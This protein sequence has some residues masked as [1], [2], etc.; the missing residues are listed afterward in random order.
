MRTVA[1]VVA[2]GLLLLGGCS[3]EA[4]SA[5]PSAGPTA[6]PT[7]GPDPSA[8]ASPTAPDSAPTDAPTP[9]DFVA[10]GIDCGLLD[11]T[12]QA[13]RDDAA[14]SDGAF[15]DAD[16]CMANALRS[17]QGATF[18]LITESLEGEPIFARFS[19]EGPGRLLITEDHRAVIA[20]PIDRRTKTCTAARSL[21]DQGPCSTVDEDRNGD[22]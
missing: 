21:T 2:A 19:V 10:A 16:R 7:A 8:A 13:A 12:A 15:A 18:R 20:S 14:P 9:E 5:A 6:G 17:G 22:G 1:V 3:D 11:Q 4:P